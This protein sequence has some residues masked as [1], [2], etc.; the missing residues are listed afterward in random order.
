MFPMISVDIWSVYIPWKVTSLNLTLLDFSKLLIRFA[1]S[2]IIS[3]QFGGRRLIPRFGVGLLIIAAI[4]RFSSYLA[5]VVLAPA[6]VTVLLAIIPCSFFF[7]FVAPSVT[8]ET[9]RMEKLTGCFLMLMHSAF[10]SA[11][12]LVGS[13]VGV[14]PVKLEVPAHW[15]FPVTADIRMLVSLLLWKICLQ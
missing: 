9:F 15:V 3:T 13:I 10:F 14:T 7:N 8:A 1:I 5:L 6:Y 11:E 2:S 12:P 4:F